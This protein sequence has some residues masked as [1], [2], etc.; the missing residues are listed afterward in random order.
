MVITEEAN[1]SVVKAVATD[2]EFTNIK[3]ALVGSAELPTIT[4]DAISLD[5]ST[6]EGTHTQLVLEVQKLASETTEPTSSNTEYVWASVTVNG[7]G[8]ITDSSSVVASSKT[9]LN[10]STKIVD[11]EISN[12]V[13][14][15]TLVHNAAE[16]DAAVAAKSKYIMLANDISHAGPVQLTYSATI[17]GDGHKL[18]S[19]GGAANEQ[20]DTVTTNWKFYHSV[21]EIQ[22]ANI[23]VKITNIDLINN[24]TS[25]TALGLVRTA[26][27]VNIV[28][29]NSYLSAKQ[30][31]V[32][33]HVGSTYQNIT[34]NYVSFDPTA[35]NAFYWRGANGKFVANNT[36]FTSTNTTS[37]P[38][39]AFTTFC[40]E[41][42]LLINDEVFQS[43]GNEFI[44]TNCS[45]AKVQLG[46]NLQKLFLCGSENNIIRFNNTD[47]EN[48]GLIA[49]GG[50]MTT[51]GNT[52]D[53]AP[54]HVFVDG[55]ESMPL[56]S[57]YVNVSKSEVG[58]GRVYW[59]ESGFYSGT[60]SFNV[61]TVATIYTGYIVQNNGNGT[62][63][64]VPQE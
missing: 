7:S 26:T 32:Y 62:W 60:Y 4:R 25:G 51:D 40:V 58:D 30:Y 28:V 6:T 9:E 14:H 39:N 55:K 38:T 21:I 50:K 1:I 53:M 63:S 43:S 34:L 12:S 27:N 8:K 11:A 35:Y 42:P 29:E 13:V 64:I 17:D 57:G 24:R 44:F 45:F 18:T 41:R 22:A 47:F 46:S 3:L 15:T 16:L 56:N 2:D 52:V 54:S 10:E 49:F 36:N 23:D 31:C 19:T 48:T 33:T 37:T 20:T 59:P 5:S 61:S